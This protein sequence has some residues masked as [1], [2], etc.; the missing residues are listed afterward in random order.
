MSLIPTAPLPLQSPQH[1]S[2]RSVGNAHMNIIAPMLI[3]I[4]EWF[5]IVPLLRRP[6]VNHQARWLASC[7]QSLKRS[8]LPDTDKKLMVS[9]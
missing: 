1:A 8:A 9:L 3:Q 4:P 7:G 6:R 5:M 2:T